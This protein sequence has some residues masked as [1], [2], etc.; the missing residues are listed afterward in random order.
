[1]KVLRNL[2]WTL[3]P[4]LFAVVAIQLGALMSHAVMAKKERRTDGVSCAQREKA[5]RR[6]HG[7]TP[8]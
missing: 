5:L 2:S 4:V 1:M 7:T 8:G 6:L 3:V